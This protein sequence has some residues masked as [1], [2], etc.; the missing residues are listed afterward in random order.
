VKETYR[1]LFVWAVVFNRMRLAQILWKQ[2]PDQV[3]S[4]LVAGIIFKSLARK[5]TPELANKLNSNAR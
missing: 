2:C 3:G 5:A 1:E 4:A